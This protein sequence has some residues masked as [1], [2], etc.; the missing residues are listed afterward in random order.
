M[1]SSAMASA[2]GVAMPLT[3]AIVAGSAVAYNVTAAPVARPHMERVTRTA[4]VVDSP[5][6]HKCLQR[7]SRFS[8][9]LPVPPFSG[10]SSVRAESRRALTVVAKVSETETKSEISVEASEATDELEDTLKSAL[11]S[12]QEAWDKLDDKLAVGGLGFAALIVLW[13]STGLI[14]AIDKLP[15]IP[16]VFEFVGILFSGWFVYRYLLF[17]PDREELLKVI[18]DAKSK[19]TGQ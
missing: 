6:I 5:D 9:L 17:K 12:V 4:A 14:G 7:K 11:K 3:T 13:A 15:L 1:A 10:S 18:D 16:A 2:A 19:I 8:S